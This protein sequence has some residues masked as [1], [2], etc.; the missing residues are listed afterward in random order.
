MIK[1]ITVETI[2]LFGYDWYRFGRYYYRFQRVYYT[3]GYYNDYKVYH[4]ETSIYNIEEDT[5]KSLVWVGTLNI[6]DP[7]SITTTV[8]DYVARI[9]NQ[10]EREGI[11]DPL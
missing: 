6:V 3:P 5:E 11:I 9:T 10:L 4:V 7:Y 8:N 1:G 2:T